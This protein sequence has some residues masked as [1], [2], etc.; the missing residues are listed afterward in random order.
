MT[1]NYEELWK[2][3][4]SFGK[5]INY[6][7]GFGDNFN[8]KDITKIN[9]FDDFEISKFECGFDHTIC[10]SKSKKLIITYFNRK[11]KSIFI[12]R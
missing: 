3:I 5:N 2:K 6:Q 11:W 7:L 1:E 8:K 10:F 4:F 9:L 12:R